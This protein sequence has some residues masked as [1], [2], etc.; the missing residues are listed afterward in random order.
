MRRLKVFCALCLMLSLL[1]ARSFAQ[2]DK[3]KPLKVP[4]APDPKTAPPA[5]DPKKK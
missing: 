3:K 1:S 4:P 5:P 2:D